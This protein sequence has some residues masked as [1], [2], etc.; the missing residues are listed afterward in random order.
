MQT[1]RNAHIPKIILG[2]SE[3]T[4]ILSGTLLE[5]LIAQFHDHS[6]ILKEI[7]SFRHKSW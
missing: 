7:R 3:N 5:H 6:S 1:L 4:S 2:T